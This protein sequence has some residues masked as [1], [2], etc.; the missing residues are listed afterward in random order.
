[1]QA[2]WH[3]RALVLTLLRAVLETLAK[4]ELVT[5]TAA[6]GRLSVDGFQIDQHY[7]RVRAG[8]AF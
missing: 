5:P 1:M 8:L 7:N 2:E 6:G 4:A 3:L